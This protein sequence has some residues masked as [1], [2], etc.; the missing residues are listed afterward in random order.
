[1]L[2]IYSQPVYYYNSVWNSIDH[3]LRAHNYYASLL[4]L[5]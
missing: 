4:S 2:K 3:Y 1:M 5:M